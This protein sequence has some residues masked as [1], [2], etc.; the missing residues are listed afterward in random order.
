MGRLNVGKFAMFV[1]GNNPL[2]PNKNYWDQ[3]RAIVVA[4]LQKKN[5]TSVAKALEEG[6]DSRKALFDLNVRVSHAL[7]HEYSLI[8]KTSESKF[9]KWQKQVQNEL[10]AVDK[11]LTEKY[12][13]SLKDLRKAKIFAVKDDAV[14]AVTNVRP[15]TEE[16]TLKMMDC[17]LPNWRFDLL[18]G[19]NNTILGLR[20]ETSD[21]T[22]LNQVLLTK[23]FE[24][25]KC[26]GDKLAVR[27]YLLRELAAYAIK[28]EKARI[29]IRAWKQLDYKFKLTMKNIHTMSS[30]ME[31]LIRGKRE[32]KWRELHK[33]YGP[34][35]LQ[36]LFAPILA[37]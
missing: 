31:E 14:K 34:E 3:Q 26:E 6:P 22:D 28:A 4:K 15:L 5:L 16:L 10:A 32:R 18:A 19:V 9:S 36:E 23:E 2:E 29:G 7:R 25:M 8:S 37:V 27:C 17:Y 24:T 1:R 35:Q 11:E 33:Q 21:R 13:C 20:E 12:D 30:Q